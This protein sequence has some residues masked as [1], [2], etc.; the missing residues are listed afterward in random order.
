M[1]NYIVPQVLINQLISEVQL[2]TIKNQ[3]VLVIGPN[4][5]LFRYTDAGEKAKCYIGQYDGKIV[6]DASGEDAATM[7]DFREE[8][9]PLDLRKQS[10][11]TGVI[12]YPELPA[13]STPDSSYARLYADNV[14]I[15]LFVAEGFSKLD[16]A[17]AGA[18]F[19]GQIRFDFALWGKR[20]GT[21][22]IYTPADPCNDK[23]AE[24]RYGDTV[25]YD[26]KRDIVKGDVIRIPYVDGD[27]K[28]Q[29]F[30]SIINDVFES[31]PNSDIYDCI[32]LEDTLPAELG[33]SAETPVYSG[34]VVFCAMFDAVDIPQKVSVNDVNNWTTYDDPEDDEYGIVVDGGMQVA[35]SN[36]GDGMYYAKVIEADLYVQYRSLLRTATTDIQTIASHT[37]VE[38]ALGTVHPD[39][40]LAF[41]V[42]MAALNS[43]DRLVYYCGVATNDLSGYNEVLA[44]ASLT[45]EVYMI[46]PLTMNESVI[47]SVKAHVEE[48]SS[49]ENKLWRIGFVSQ[50]PPTTD[51]IYDATANVDNEPFYAKFLKDRDGE[52]T[53]MQFMWD[54]DE[55]DARANTVVKCLSQVEPGDVVKVFT[56][57]SQ[58]TWD[59]TPKY[60]EYYVRKVVSNTVLRL[61]RPVDIDPLD[62]HDDEYE[63][64]HTGLCCGP[65]HHYK[66]EV[67]RKLSHARQAKYIADLS[68]SLATRRMYNVFPSVASTDG[69]A[70][71]GE[72]LAAA[73]AGLVSSVLPQ[74]P[75]TNVE[76]NGI[77]DIPLVYQTFSRQELNTIAA[78]GTFIIM[79]DRPGSQV[80][81]RH[82]IS[83]AYSEGNLLK[84]ELSITKNL[85]SISY[86]FAELFAPLI[87]K[88]NITPELLDVIRSRLN[89]GL[90][91]LETATG[92]GMYGPQV[93][94]DGTEILELRQSEVNRDHVY[95][96]V[97]LNLPVPFNYFDLD[98]EI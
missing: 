64:P 98:L 73:A 30:E 74:Q 44:K 24:V 22:V 26:V 66:V 94:A 59:D 77:G 6:K 60:T 97:H 1:A 92:A 13:D 29:V 69:V 90:T 81:V 47:D 72:F 38:N 82:Q 71:G 78:G 43:G 48:M 96:K 67:Y 61:T 88:Y 68:S 53:L 8:L 51:M 93:L 17:S 27:G 62:D 46:V 41:G 80:Y 12:P 10:E 83:T 28:D 95:A 19:D 75:V 14:V 16:D 49:A 42:Y 56:E 45:D 63:G 20:R 84:S 4:Y 91:A 5:A 65:D 3:N 33:V 18:D 7:T 34:E 50:E 89:G 35:Y 76:L 32:R 54:D 86:Y 37:L 11:V 70:F 87:G 58:D 85:D 25:K 57:N 52:Y 31:V 79:Q 55:E 2:N 21:E 15:Q 36:W 9:L 39:N 40:P 23:E